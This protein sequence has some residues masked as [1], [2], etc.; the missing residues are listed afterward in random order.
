MEPQPAFHQPCV[1]SWVLHITLT[2]SV[3]RRLT[4]L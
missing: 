4:I 1:A 2:Y 3:R